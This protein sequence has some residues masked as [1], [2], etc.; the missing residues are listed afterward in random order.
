MDNPNLEEIK[1]LQK[2]F[3]KFRF[4]KIMTVTQLV[5]ILGVSRPMWYYWGNGTYKMSSTT[6]L[7]LKAIIEHL[8][9]ANL[10][11][12]NRIRK[13]VYDFKFSIADY[14]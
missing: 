6:Y 13:G 7:V 5:K 12:L 2:R 4:H 1:D 10:D 11:E 9:K 8:E 14:N 3:A